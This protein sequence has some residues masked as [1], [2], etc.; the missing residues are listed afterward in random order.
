MYPSIPTDPYEKQL[1][2]LE[3]TITANS[4]A[5]EVNQSRLAS[6]AH[7]DSMRAHEDAEDL[8]LAIVGSNAALAEIFEQEFSDIE[9]GISRMGNGIDSVRSAVWSMD[10]SLQRFGQAFLAQIQH[11]EEM[12]AE[13]MDEIKSR[14]EQVSSSLSTISLQMITQ[15]ELLSDTY[16]MQE[17]MFSGIISS[18]DSL[19]ET[20]KHPLQTEARELFNRGVKSYSRQLLTEA[21]EDFLISIEKHKTEPLAHYFLSKIYLFGINDDENLID[22]DKGIAELKLAQ[23]YTKPDLGKERQVDLF[24]AE[25]LKSLA[26]A[27]YM[28]AKFEEVLNV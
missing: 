19:H 24:Y 21:K 4:F 8:K 15:N 16:N 12:N 14:I 23:R 6:Q 26:N 22:I 5:Q 11:I 28:K 18:I 9:Y 20:A 1:L 7:H 27:Y 2:H 17:E 3:R 25:I 13:R 10:N